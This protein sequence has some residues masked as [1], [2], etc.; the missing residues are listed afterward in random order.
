VTPERVDAEPG[1][2]LCVDKIRSRPP[3]N[4]CVDKIRSRPRKN[5]CVD[6]CLS[7]RASLCR[8]KKLTRTKI[9]HIIDFS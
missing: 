6:K 8:S 1:T 2:P 4:L 3:E 9:E 7:Q 5:I